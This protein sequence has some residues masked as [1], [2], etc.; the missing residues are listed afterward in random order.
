MVEDYVA[1]W[2]RYQS[3]WDLQPD[4]LVNR[5]KESITDWMKVLADIKKSRAT[6]D[7]SETQRSFGPIII[8]F[9]KVQGKVSNKY[10]A[11]HKDA[12][13]KFGVMIGQ[14]MVQF[15][16]QIAKART[17]LEIQTIEAASTSDAVNFITEV[18][19]LKRK[20]KAWDKQVSCQ[21]YGI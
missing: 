8:D 2:L 19:Q 1:E 14:E 16:S 17:D 6:F 7:T 9:G 10:D 5:F 12:L 20:M 15:H 3:L 21:E 4:S 13:S 11:W 18:Q